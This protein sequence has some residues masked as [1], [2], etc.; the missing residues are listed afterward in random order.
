MEF[1]SPLLTVHILSVIVWLGC[2]LYEIFL[3]REMKA[4]RGTSFEL[5]LTRLYIKYGATVPVAT[6]L[7]AGTGA[8]MAIVLKWGFFEHFWLGMKQGLMVAV[9]I[10]FAS[11]I[12]AFYKFTGIVNSLSAGVEALPEEAAQIFGRL[13][14]WLITMR[15]MGAIAVGFAVFKPGIQ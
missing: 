15:V 4:A 13:E 9:L 5:Q 1:R 12:P 8:V 11:I 7:V 6:L 14:K 2:G 10:I 3:A